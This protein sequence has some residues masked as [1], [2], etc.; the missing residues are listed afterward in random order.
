MDTRNFGTEKKR[1]FRKQK[2]KFL[3]IYSDF[4]TFT[5]TCF[6]ANLTHFVYAAVSRILTSQRILTFVYVTAATEAQAA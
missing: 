4:V 3:S 5:K 2:R 6:N 1:C